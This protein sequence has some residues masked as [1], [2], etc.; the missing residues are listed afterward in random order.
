MLPRVSQKMTEVV[1]SHEWLVQNIDLGHSGQE[2]LAKEARRRTESGLLPLHIVARCGSN[3]RAIQELLSIYPRAARKMNI[4]GW[5]P[6]HFA[7]RYSSSIECIVLIYNQ[8]PRAARV[9]TKQSCIEDVV[10]T[11][12]QLLCNNEANRHDSTFTQRA[13]KACPF[14]SNTSPFSLPSLE[15]VEA[16]SLVYPVAVTQQISTNDFRAHARIPYTHNQYSLH[17]ICRRVPSAPHG[18]IAEI[19][20]AYPTAAGIRTEYGWF[21]LHILCRN[22]DD[23]LAIELVLKAFPDAAK[24]PTPDG[25]LP[26][27]QLCRYSH[28]L[29]AI[30]IV[31]EAYPKAAGTPTLKES[32]PID[33][34]RKYF[35][36]PQ[37]GDCRYFVHR[38]TIP[39]PISALFSLIPY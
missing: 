22:S 31:L 32:L 14:M 27:H 34:F 36:H 29:D 33:L 8:F 3:I 9:N 18:A 1:D 17:L 21:P 6:F 35:P 23:A 30:R 13:C 12:Y 28:S 39:S 11:P 5:L 37:V 38:Y 19:L 2:F 26:L 24:T 7:I 15:T 4:D 16:D 25:F 10:T 20:S